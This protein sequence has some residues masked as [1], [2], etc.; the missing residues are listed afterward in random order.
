MSNVPIQTKVQV[1]SFEIEGLLIVSTSAKSLPSGRIT[2]AF[3][4]NTTTTSA[5]AV[6]R[7]SIRDKR[8]QKIIYEIASFLT[9]EQR[10]SEI[11]NIPIDNNMEAFLTV[12]NLQ[13][14][15]TAKIEGSLTVEYLK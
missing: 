11:V 10:Y 2:S 8:T 13:A 3:L 4:N 15:Q 5:G 12:E 7:L 1:Y 14:G 6:G 9:Y